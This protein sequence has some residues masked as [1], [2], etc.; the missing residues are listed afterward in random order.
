MSLISE[1]RPASNRVPVPPRATPA[2]YL[3]GRSTSERAR[4]EG[5][6]KSGD[7]IVHTL[8]SAEALVGR[9]GARATG[10]ALVA[11]S[12]AETDAFELQRH[13]AAEHPEM[14]L[15]FMTCDGDIAMSVRAMKAGA[16][17]FLPKPIQAESLLGTIRKAMDHGQAMLGRQIEL[18]VLRRNHDSLTSREREVM[19]SIVSGRLNKQVAGVLGITEFTVKVHRGQVMRKMNAKSF[20][21]LVHQADRLGLIG[22][23]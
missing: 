22:S 8:D 13:L 7:F 4:L 20:A 12:Q 10:V 11:A 5:I 1:S 9:L 16:F 6:I 21:A 14:P 18:D 23:V 2:V 17:D 3:I 15:V 19:A